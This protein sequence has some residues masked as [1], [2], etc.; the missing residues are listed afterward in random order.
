MEHWKLFLFLLFVSHVL[1]GQLPAEKPPLNSGLGSDWE[2]DGFSYTDFG[3]GE[4]HSY[5]SVL[6]KLNPK[7]HAELR[8][9]YDSYRTSDIFDVSVRMRWYPTKKVYLFSG[10]GMQRQRGKGGIELPIMEVR[11]LNGVG[12]EPNKKITIE[13]V[14]DLN[15]NTNN[16]GSNA[17]PSLLTLKGKYRF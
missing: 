7:L 1:M 11:M 6:Y 16:A 5:F 13:A 4:E 3:T 14:H 2:Y 17:T 15:F 9:F 8:G 10:V 12:Y